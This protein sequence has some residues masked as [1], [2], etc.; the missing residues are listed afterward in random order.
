M[1]DQERADRVA[2][3]WKM[4]LAKTRGAVQVILTFGDL[5]RR[6]FLYGSTKK[7]IEQE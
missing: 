5:N 7:N 4:A 6:I 2:H 1:T 3:L